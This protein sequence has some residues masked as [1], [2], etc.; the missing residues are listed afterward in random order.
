MLL[1]RALAD[2]GALALVLEVLAHRGV[3]DDAAGGGDVALLH[4]QDHV[5]LVRLV[6][7]LDQQVV[8]GQAGAADPEAGRADDVLDGVEDLRAAR[9]CRAGSSPG[10][11]SNASSTRPR[12][13][14]S[15]SRARPERRK[16]RSSPS[17]SVRPSSSA[18]RVAGAREAE[19][20]E[21]V[22]L[23]GVE[24]QRMRRVVL[25]LDVDVHPLDVGAQ[26]AGG[27]LA[28]GV[29]GQRLLPAH[30]REARDEPA[31]VPGEVADVGLV[32]VVDVE[33]QHAVRVHV[34]AEVLRV[35]VA[36]DPDAA[37]ALVGPAVLELAHVGVEHAG[38]AAVERERVG[39]HLAELRPERARRRPSSAARTPPSASRG[40]TR[41]AR[42]RPGSSGHS[43]GW[44]ARPAD[45]G[46]P[47]PPAT[48]SSRDPKSENRSA[49]P[50][51]SKT[52]R[53]WPGGQ[54]TVIA[55]PSCP[56][57]ARARMNSVRPVESRKP[58]SERS[59]TKRARA[60]ADRLVD[61][62][63]HARRRDEVELPAD[64]HAARLAQ[65]ERSAPKS[66]LA[67]IAARRRRAPRRSR[68]DRPRSRAASA[69]PRSPA[70]RAR[71][72]AAAPG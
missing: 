14:S 52:P 27:E 18:I 43:C 47:T 31:Q 65:R 56:S 8:R 70:Q 53:A 16:R 46:S 32:E 39:G 51:D 13:S 58:S 22:A 5:V 71:S 61:E 42:H 41:S 11:R 20:V 49:M 63:G 19:D 69:P 35:Q 10:R 25:F 30:Q 54:M 33:R 72:G 50:A 40:S 62:R 29:L 60:R 12:S 45:S 66:G 67:I 36:V 4:G 34:R 55:R 23:G 7:A 24:L 1:Q 9:A 21:D 15:S 64:R 26:V 17:S 68:R 48:A 2:H 37:R 3:L 38:A 57:S 6:A 28:H 44:T 59:M